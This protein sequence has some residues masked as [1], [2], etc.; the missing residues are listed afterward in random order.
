MNIELLKVRIGAQIDAA[1]KGGIFPGIEFDFK[2]GSI[3]PIT[4][5]LRL[6]FKDKLGKIR[7]K[8]VRIYVKDAELI[9]PVGGIVE[10]LRVGAFEISVE[11]KTEGFRQRPPLDGFLS[12]LVTKRDVLLLASNRGRL[13]LGERIMDM[14]N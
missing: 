14:G 8:L 10:V 7:P 6:P 1:D 5:G 13:F 9:D 2:P 4:G 3:Q 11:P 12:R